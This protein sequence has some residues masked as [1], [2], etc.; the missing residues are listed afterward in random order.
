MHGHSG[1]GAQW[2]RNRYARYGRTG[3]STRGLIRLSDSYLGLFEIPVD[4][5][6]LNPDTDTELDEASDISVSPGRIRA[7]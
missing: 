4:V 6:D 1:S 2:Q 3:F 7:E 5:V